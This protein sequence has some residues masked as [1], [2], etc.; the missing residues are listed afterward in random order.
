M[1][2]RQ[3]AVIGSGI[4]GL[5]AAYVLQQECDVTLLE[6]D[7]RLGGHADTHDLIDDAGAPVSIDTGFIVHNRRTYPNLL[8]LFDEL[9]V[10]TQESDMSMSIRCEGC[11][12]EY[13]GGRGLAGLLP[14]WRTARHPRYLAML[15]GVVR[16]HRRARAALRTAETSAVGKHETVDEFV[17]RNG[18]SPYFVS[19]FLTP[20][21]AAVWSI[22]PTEAGAYPAHY[23]FRF[24]AHHGM[25][26]VTGSPPWRTVTGGSA[27]YVE[28]VAKG[29]TAVRTSSPVDAV[30]RVAGGVEVIVDGQ[31]EHYD[32]AVIA[33]HPDQALRML[34]EATDL[35]RRALGGIPY[36]QNPT[37]L[38]HDVSVLPR[39]ARAGASW[40]YV[41]QSCDVGSDQVHVSYDMNRL[42]RL[43]T[44]TRY[45][46]TLN[47]DAAVPTAAVVA[48]M[49]YAHPMYTAGSVAAQAL[50]PECSDARL[51]FAGAYHGWGFHED[52]ARSGVAA[53]R[54]L[55][56]QW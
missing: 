46:V 53:A 40:N 9:G 51:A 12:L 22:A 43:P 11:G 6:A 55:G 19:H 14:T 41:M 10:A 32:A 45:I 37:V 13:A 47:A 15:A 23:L 54:A 4:A 2:R 30:C 39:S 7:S 34:S 18:F 27:R 38:H 36:S 44:A 48:R 52:G 25:L 28:L 20:L 42:Q 16:F 1:A 8:R 50:L 49:D 5:M 21:V 29:L 31:L 26:Q 24:L 35:E 56:V 17:A 3:V 33:T